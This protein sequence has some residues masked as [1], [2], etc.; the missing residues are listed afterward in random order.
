MKKCEFVKLKIKLLGHRIL[1]ENTILDS[2]KVVAIE[3]LKWPTTIS[4]L[5]RFLE[6]VDFFK[7]YIQEFEQIAKP[8]ND[9]I[10]I[11]FKNC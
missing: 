2:G 6:A 7:K 4:K 5:K 11:K 9:I 3:A 10:L 1:A 8:L